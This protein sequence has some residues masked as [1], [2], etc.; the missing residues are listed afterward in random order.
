MKVLVTSGPTSIP[1]DPMRVITNRSSGEMGRLIVNAFMQQGHHVTLLEGHATTTVLASASKRIT[2]YTFDEFLKL[3]IKELK[4]CSYDIIIHAAAVSDFK[5]KKYFK[6]KISSKGSLRLEFV[7]TKKV[8][9]LIK[10]YQPHTT[11][12]GFKL[13]SDI[14]PNVIKDKIKCLFEEALCDMVVVNKTE[15]GYCAYLMMPNQKKT[16]DV[17][18]KKK[19]VQLLVKECLRIK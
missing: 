4:T 2:F 7:S 14:R 18:S 8:I 12:V 10:K 9:N 15:R 3:F 13:E 19:I 11:L 6:K 1:I 16:L 17:T 5:L